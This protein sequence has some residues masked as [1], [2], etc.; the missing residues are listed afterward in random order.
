MRSYT[1][2]GGCYRTYLWTVVAS[3]GTAGSAAVEGA[4]QT[5]FQRG[6]RQ[7]ANTR[8]DSC[9]GAGAARAMVHAPSRRGRPHHT[10][11]GAT[12]PGAPAMGRHVSLRIG[13]FFLLTPRRIGLAGCLGLGLGLNS[14][15]RATP[16]FLTVSRS[17]NLSFPP[18]LF[19]KSYFKENPLRSHFLRLKFLCMSSHVA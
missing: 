4:I 11:R 14:Q 15:V 13:L 8:K 16:A 12:G 9:D 7:I 6:H 18:N 19:L 10:G 1:D 3:G 17:G 5:G 2:T